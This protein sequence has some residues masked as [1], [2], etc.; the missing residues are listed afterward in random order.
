MLQIS[1]SDGSDVQYASVTYVE[2]FLHILTV[3]PSVT[4]SISEGG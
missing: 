4:A 2:L 3:T 1:N